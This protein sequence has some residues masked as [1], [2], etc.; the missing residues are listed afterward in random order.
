MEL[1]P[2]LPQ[3]QEFHLY[4]TDRERA[5]RMRVSQEPSGV[6]SLYLQLGRSRT[7]LVALKGRVYIAPKYS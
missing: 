4:G 7:W 6:V 2:Y 5:V 3:C 1:R